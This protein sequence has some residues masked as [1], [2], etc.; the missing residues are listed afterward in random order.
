MIC[1]IIAIANHSWKKGF[2]KDSGGAIFAVSEFAAQVRQ[3]N[4]FSF[5]FNSL[6]HT[7]TLKIKTWYYSCRNCENVKYQ[8]GLL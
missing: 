3:A 6:C 1:S 4:K 7:E 8:L 2:K 5:Y